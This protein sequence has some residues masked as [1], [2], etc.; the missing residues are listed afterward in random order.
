MSVQ[1]SEREE[2]TDFQ[3]RKRQA[4]QNCYIVGDKVKLLWSLQL[5]TSDI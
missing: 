4:V 2:K 3:P 5:S 1:R